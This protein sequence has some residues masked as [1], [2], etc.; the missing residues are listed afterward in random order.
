[1]L[2]EMKLKEVIQLVEMLKAKLD[3]CDD[4]WCV[5]NSYFIRT[6]TMHLIGNLIAINEKEM[7]LGN[8]VWIAD[9]GRFHD[10][11]KTGKLNE[12]EPFVDQ[13][14]VNRASIV[15]ATIWK[16]PVPTKQQ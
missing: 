6:V 14:I 15:D 1:M 9:S 4:F 5:G 16:H 10:A 3:V 8:A 11:L 2:E 13:V 12:V 7:L